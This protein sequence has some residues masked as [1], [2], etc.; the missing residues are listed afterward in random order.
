MAQR[1]TQGRHII[2]TTDATS[3]AQNPGCRR[4]LSRNTGLHKDRDGN[5]FTNTHGYI[6]TDM[7]Q[8]TEEET[9][10]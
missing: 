9:D 1:Q 3:D 4:Q 2:Q 5:A 8:T 6:P 7:R 10:G